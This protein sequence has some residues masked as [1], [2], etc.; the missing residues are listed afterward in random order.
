MSRNSGIL[1]SYNHKLE[2]ALLV[3]LLVAIALWLAV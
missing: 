1:R 2:W 3:A